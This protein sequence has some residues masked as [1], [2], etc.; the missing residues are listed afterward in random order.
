[1]EKDINVQI[2]DGLMCEITQSEVWGSIW[3][4]D[5]AIVKARDQ[6]DAVLTRVEGMIP[7]ELYVELSDTL[8]WYA[9]VA[10]DAGILYGMQVIFA[11]RDV[12]ARPF[13]LSRYVLVKKEA[14]V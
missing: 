5:P 7:R 3:Y 14:T 12:A 10:G 9:S 13:D 6:V 4:N 11:M 2:M 1:M 8:S